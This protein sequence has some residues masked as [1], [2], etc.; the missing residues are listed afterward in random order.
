MI[1]LNI[2][3]FGELN[4]EHLVIDYNGTLAY[5]GVLLPGAADRLRNLGESLRIH[6]LTADTHGSVRSEFAIPGAELHI[7]PATDQSDAKADY[8]RRLDADT[9]IA[10]GNGRNDGKMLGAAAV[11]IAVIQGEGAAMEA[12]VHA[13][14]VVTRV[15]DALDM[16]L[17]PKRL[18]ATLR[19]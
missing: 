2:P 18:I 6:V 1:E 17:K 7:V 19:A 8:V 9:V 3:G 4:L 5:D 10:V 15:V 13:D 14:V 12:I 16:L 11:G